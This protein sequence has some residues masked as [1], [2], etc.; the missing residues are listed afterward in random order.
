[1]ILPDGRSLNRERVKEGM[2]W[3]YRNFAPHDAELA[4][5]E[6]E[7]REAR[8]GLWS[9][10]N[11]VPPWGWRHGNAVPRTAAVIGN[12]R[13]RVDHKPTCRGAAR[14][15]EKNRVTFASEADAEKAGYRKAGDCW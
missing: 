10:P 3:W 5:L 12:R 15:G 1:V 13:S 8:I 2:A 6:A 9:R 7:A 11:P 4:R 14:M